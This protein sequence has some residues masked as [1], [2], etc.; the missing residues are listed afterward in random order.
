MSKS[1]VYVDDVNLLG[2]NINTTTKNTEV[3]IDASKELE[4][5]ARTEKINP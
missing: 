5:E 1:L 2:E 3:L 4:L